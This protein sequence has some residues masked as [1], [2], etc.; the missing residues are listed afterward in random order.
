MLNRLKNTS[1]GGLVALGC[2]IVKENIL[3]PIED[4]VKI[5]QKTILDTPTNKLTDALIGI[6]SGISGLVEINKTVRADEAVQRAFGRER[7]AEQ[8]VIN[9]TFNACTAENVTQMQQANKVIFQQHSQ[10]YVHPYQQAIQILDVD[11]SGHP[12][13]KQ[14]A[15]A[16]KGYFAGERNRRGR[17]IGR[18][19]ASHY[20]EIVVERLY[21][22][23]TTLPTVLPELVKATADVLNLDAAKRAQTIWR[24]DR[25]GGSLANV[26]DMLVEGY[27]L[28][29][30]E[31]STARARKLA[32][33]VTHWYDDPRHP[34]R[35]VGLVTTATTEYHRPL[36]RIAVRTR[37]KNQQWGVGVL[38]STL[39]PEQVG[40]LVG[41]RPDEWVKPVNQLLAYVYFYDQRG[42]GVESSFEQDKQ[43]LGIVKRNMKKFEAQQMMTELNALAHNLLVWFQQSLAQCSPFIQYLGI[44]RLIRDVLH[45]NSQVVY[46]RFETIRVLKFNA[47][48]QMARKLQFAFQHLFDP[49]HLD[50]ILDKT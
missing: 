38:L 39:S 11:L 2:H 21:P 7:C 10:S 5:K 37:K 50:I 35:Q 48:D 46:D 43:G 17:Q 3:K 18:V 25:H 26:N 32:E 44:M 6:L 20:Q 31:Y 22:G 1:L 41:F 45:M 23:N 33:S 36:T 29:T 40:F 13:G 16:T 4:Y 9:G 14:A 24:I 49:E 19:L 30:K 47:L 8:S 15:F 34:G 42:G 12:C 27:Q 28:H